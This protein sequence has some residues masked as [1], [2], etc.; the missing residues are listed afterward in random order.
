MI[1]SQL[2]L[3]IGVLWVIAAGFYHQTIPKIYL[4]FMGVGIMW[5]VIGVIHK[6][7]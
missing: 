1:E 7:F 5:M 2:D 3:I 6:I 4:L